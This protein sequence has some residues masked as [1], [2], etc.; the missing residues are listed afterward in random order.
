MAAKL[1]ETNLPT[2]LWDGEII[3][4]PAPAP[5]HQEI[6]LSFASLLRH[7]VARKKLGKVFVSPVDVVLSQRRAVQPDVVYISRPRLEMVQEVIR[8]VPDLVVEVVSQG[9]WKR[10][11]VDKKGLY[12]QFGVMEYWIIDPEAR[13]I[14]VFILGRKGYELSSR[15]EWGESADSKLLAG[16]SVSW[17]EL[18]A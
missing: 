11:R 8:G 17:A 16:F 1:P 2:E 7:F 15:A 14:E 9:S 4:S 6:V 5:S 10:D 18:T 13:T 12:E 3:R